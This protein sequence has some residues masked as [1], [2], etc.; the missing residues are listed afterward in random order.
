M[1]ENKTTTLIM[2]IAAAVLLTSCAAAVSNASANDIVGSPEHATQ[3]QAIA[4]PVTAATPKPVVQVNKDPATLTLAF[5][6][7]YLD[8]MPSVKKNRAVFAKYLTPKFLGVALKADDY[9]PFLDAQDFDETWKDNNYSVKGTAVNGDKA[10]V[11]VDLNGESLKW[12]LKV[13]LLRKNGLWKIDG[14]KNSE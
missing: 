10:T 6:E 12:T 8:G 3:T 4:P 7:Y 2:I 5:Y 13:S 11:N 9:D 14:V 1:A